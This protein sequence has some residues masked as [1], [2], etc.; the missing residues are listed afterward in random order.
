[1]R[2]AHAFKICKVDKNVIRRSHMQLCIN[3]T[4]WDFETTL[5]WVQMD[6]ATPGNQMIISNQRR[7]VTWSDAWR[8][9]HL[10][11]I[12]RPKN[13][14]F[15]E[16]TDNMISDSSEMITLIDCLSVALVSHSFTFSCTCLCHLSNKFRSTRQHQNPQPRIQEEPS[17]M[18]FDFSNHLCKLPQSGSSMNLH[19]LYHQIS[20]S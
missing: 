15:H 20:L 4:R 6:G 12:N 7:N 1:M 16:R 5:I 19:V 13:T 3:S 10:L 8:K 17:Y 2:L 18:T 9:T 11:S 14:K